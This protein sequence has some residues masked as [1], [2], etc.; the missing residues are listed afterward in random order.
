MSVAN[1]IATLQ[2]HLAGASLRDEGPGVELHPTLAADVRATPGGGPG[3]LSVTDNRTGNR[4]EIKISEHG[5]I[6]ATDLKQ[7]TAGGDGV[8]LRTYDNG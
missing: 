2:R 7:I 3:S 8:G 5:T 1:R 4:Y 6:K